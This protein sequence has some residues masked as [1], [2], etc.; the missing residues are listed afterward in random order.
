MAYSG[1]KC[2]HVE[3]L[4]AANL[5]STP[6]VVDGFFGGGGLSLAHGQA[7][8][9]VGK[10]LI[11]GESFAP[12]RRLYKENNDLESLADM[13]THS[14]SRIGITDTWDDLRDGLQGLPSSWEPDEA[15]L[16][17]NNLGYGNSMRHGKGRHNIQ[18]CKSKIAGMTARGQLID[19]ISVRPDVVHDCWHKAIASTGGED[20]TFLGDPPYQESSAIYPNQDW[21]ACA[22][23]PVEMAMQRNYGCIGVF[24]NYS[25]SLHS[26]FQA[27]ALSH[28]Y[29]I[30]ANPTHWETRFKPG[31]KPKGQEWLWVFLP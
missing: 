4:K 9:T 11:A 14:F 24:N 16:V 27:V 15:F 12:L 8:P 28:G 5:P 17:L 20:A 13:V 3:I 31:A 23:P 2:K 6:I 30:Q 22:V 29:S 18:P 25:E 26:E 7:Y 19:P 10:T 21:K 1:S